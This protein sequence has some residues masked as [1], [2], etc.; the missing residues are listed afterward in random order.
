[1]YSFQKSRKKILKKN[2][3]RYITK[4]LRDIILKHLKALWK[5]KPNIS[6]GIEYLYW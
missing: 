1:M 6:K 4:F 5:I 3:V 2:I